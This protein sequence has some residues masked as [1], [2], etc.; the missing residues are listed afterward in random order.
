MNSL[1]INPIF[2]KVIMFSLC[3]EVLIQLYGSFWRL[4][5]VVLLQRIVLIAVYPHYFTLH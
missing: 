2:M 3:L 1:T 4:Q 5:L